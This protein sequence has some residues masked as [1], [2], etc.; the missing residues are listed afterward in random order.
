[1]NRRYSFHKSSL[2]V[3]TQFLGVVTYV[4]E[5]YWLC[6]FHIYLKIVKRE[7]NFL[8]K[9]LVN[10]NQTSFHLLNKLALENL[11]SICC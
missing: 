6:N 5:K 4:E 9:Y 3:T 1:M 2:L 7:L 8:R 11:P 10:E